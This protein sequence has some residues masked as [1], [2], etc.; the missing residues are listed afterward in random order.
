MTQNFLSSPVP[1]SSWCD[2]QS[3]QFIHSVSHTNLQV[4]DL[5]L[6]HQERFVDVGKLQDITHYYVEGLSHLTEIHM[7]L[8]NCTSI[9]YPS[10]LQLIKYTEKDVFKSQTSQYSCFKSY[11]RKL[12]KKKKI[13]FC[14]YSL[15]YKL[16][17]SSSSKN[18]RISVASLFFSYRNI[19]GKIVSNLKASSSAKQQVEIIYYIFHRAASQTHCCRERTKQ[20]VNSGLQRKLHCQS[21]GLLKPNIYV[22]LRNVLQL[23]YCSNGTL[24]CLI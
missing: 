19:Q 8:Q 15:A 9:S 2:T 24:K 18:L 10:I 17:L 23:K 16:L 7:L 3:V 1:T 20:C 14:C 13:L 11:K 12:L 21:Q 4:S 6:N 22:S 5:H